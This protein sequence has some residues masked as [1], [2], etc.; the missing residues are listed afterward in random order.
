MI[1]YGKTPSEWLAC[2]YC[3]KHKKYTIAGVIII[4]ALIVF[5]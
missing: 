1:I 3:K 4:V 5:F 2:F